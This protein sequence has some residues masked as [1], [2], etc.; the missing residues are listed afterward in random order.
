MRFSTGPKKRSRLQGHRTRRKVPIIFK[1]ADVYL[2]TMV[3]SAQ[4]TFVEYK[5]IRQY[6]NDFNK[7]TNGYQWL[8][9]DP[10]KKF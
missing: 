7:D 6:F 1:A 4:M 10:P 9:M 3:H 8:E 5:I 2:D